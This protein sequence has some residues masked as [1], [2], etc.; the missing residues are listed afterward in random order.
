M[1]G[2]KED[3]FGFEAM[4]GAWTE[5]MNAFW[6]SVS[7]PA[8]GKPDA[9]PGSENKGSSARREAMDKAAKNWR[10]MAAAMTAP[11]S[12]NALLKSAGAMPDI[13]T[14]L[15]QSTM[16]SLLELQRS[17]MA[18]A[19]RIGTSVEAY[20][21]E[22]LDENLLHVWTEIYEKEFRRF[23]QIPQLGLTRTYQE[24]LN[25]T[26]DTYNRFQST[27][28]EFLRLLTLPFNQAVVVMQD[29]V[30]ELAANGK[31]PEDSQ[32]YYRMWVK[33]LEGHFMTL[34]QTPEYVK[35]LGETIGVLTEFSEAKNAVL[36]DLLQCFPIA[37]RTELDD[38]A[39]EVYEL[40]KRIRRIEQ[41]RTPAS[42][43][44]TGDAP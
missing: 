1:G 22:N 23:F 17:A 42:T 3:P 20:R 36:E 35:T 33:V 39:Q 28:A 34:F 4:L 7:P 19:E 13:L 8:A 6:S 26:M 27:F 40:K 21:F 43:D 29:Q 41:R 9:S 11:E 14:Q 16:D 10:T 24:K 30:G 32:A 31:L 38:L 12:I 2:K 37:S 44:L 18:Q 15:T 25:V 5:T